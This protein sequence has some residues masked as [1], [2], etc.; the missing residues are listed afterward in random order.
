MKRLLLLSLLISAAAQ[1]QDAGTPALPPNMEAHQLV[2]LRRGPK[3]TPEATPQIEAL[4]KQH[5][6]HMKKMYLAGK[7]VVAGP[8]GDQK[9]ISLRGMCLYK[10]GSV[11][12]ARG[13]AEQDPM[14]K[15]GR[16][17]VEVMTWYTEK[18]AMSFPPPPT[19][20]PR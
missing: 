20:K 11:D 8:F 10:V 4:Q 16:L 14:V 12:E 9:D 2:L 1:A 18:G 6:E 3:W 19:A 5:L 13:L 15:A 17:V 7:L